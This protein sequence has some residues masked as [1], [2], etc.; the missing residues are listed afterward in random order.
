M[1]PMAT[2]AAVFPD[3][4]EPSNLS[5]LPPEYHEFADVFSETKARILPPHQTYDHKIVRVTLP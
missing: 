1:T 5:H 3:N 4:D 2:A